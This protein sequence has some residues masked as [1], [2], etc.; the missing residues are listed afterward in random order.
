MYRTSAV[1]RGF[2]LI[3]LIAVVIILAILT[4]VAWPKYIDHVA[5]IDEV[6]CR[7]SL[8]DVRAGIQN[9]YAN[10]AISGKAVYPTLLQLQTIGTVLQDVVPEN[11]YNGSAVIAAANYNAGNPPVSG[12]NGWNYDAAT[13]KFWANSNTVGENAW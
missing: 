5:K 10:A 2:T 11:P 13:G 12:V 7:G 8:G 6:T 1:R 3:E 4:A 9:F